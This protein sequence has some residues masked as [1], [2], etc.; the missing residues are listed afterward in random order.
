[1]ASRCGPTNGAFSVADPRFEQS[2]HW[3][4]GQAYGVRRW[5]DSTGAITGQQNPGQGTYSIADPR[6]KSGETERQHDA[7]RFRIIGQNPE[8]PGNSNGNVV[9]VT[10]PRPHRRGELFTKYPVTAWQH[11]TGTVIGG[12]DMGAYAVADPRLPPSDGRHYNQHRVSLWNE[13]T[14]CIT[15]AQH[16]AGGAT[17]VADPRVVGWEPNTSALNAASGH[18][19][20]R[21]CAADTRC[22]P[23]AADKLVAV[24]R[25]LDGTWHRPFTTLELAALQ[26]LV[27]PEEHLELDGLSDQAW[28]ERIGNAVPPHAAQAIAEVMGT[29]LLLAWAGETFMLSSQPIWVRPIAVALAVDLPA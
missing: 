11:H 18:V 16:V 1:V 22:M 8:A 25:A 28:R 6:F 14:N 12:D 29:T 15:G 24:I 3:N 4:D 10:D 17:S 26:S 7:N 2:Q 27:D 20:G 5:S 23:A 13:P 19:N 21:W 9:A